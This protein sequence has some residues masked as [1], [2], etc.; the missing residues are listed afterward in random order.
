MPNDWMTYTCFAF[1][2]SSAIVGG[3]FKAFSEFVMK[4]LIQAEPGSGIEAM[5]K[6]NRAV[7]RTE[8]VASLVTLGPL[9]TAFAVYAVL[10]LGGLERNLIVT[11]AIVYVSSVFL[12]TIVGNVPMN[13]RLDG[14][15]HRSREAAEYWNVYGTKWT[16]LNHVRTIGAIITSVLYL[17]AM[18][19]HV[20]GQ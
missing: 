15:Q 2:L 6:I 9:S 12:V 1:A 20:N 3:V 5:Q 10:I 17:M 19:V 11:A 8:F 18:I 14:M 16:R 7:L 4:A 13:E